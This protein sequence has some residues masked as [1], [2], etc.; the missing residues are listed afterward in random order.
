MECLTRRERDPVTPWIGGKVR[1]THVL[2]EG[3]MGVVWAGRHDAIAMD[4]A[5]KLASRQVASEVAGS[6]LRREARVAARHSHPAL[7]RVFDFGRTESGEFYLVMERLHGGTLADLLEREGPL[8]PK[9]A[10]RVLLPIA[11]ALETLH[12]GG[13]VHRD[14]KPGN[15][16]LA[17]DDSNR[18]QPKLLD[19]GISQ[20]DDPDHELGPP[21]VDRG[22]VGTPGFLAPEQALRERTDGRADIWGLCVTLFVAIAGKSLFA[23]DGL[24]PIIATRQEGHAVDTAAAFPSLPRKLARIMNKGLAPL[25][26]NRWPTMASLRRVLADWLEAQGVTTDVAGVALS[27]YVTMPRVS[28]QPDTP[29]PSQGDATRRSTNPDVESAVEPPGNPRRRGW[30]DL[31]AGVLAYAGIAVRATAAVL[32]GARAAQPSLRASR[33]LA[34]GYAVGGEHGQ[35]HW[36]RVVGNVERGEEIVSV[37]T[38]HGL[39]VANLATWS[40]LAADAKTIRSFVP[41]ITAGPRRLRVELGGIRLVFEEGAE[42]AYVAAIARAMR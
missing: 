19:F 6:R 10:V 35:D 38:R 8:A 12:K 33:L 20:I 39:S 36:K 23:G 17:R 14:I 21:L 28:S 29:L 34:G 25:A 18:L 30:R 1:L 27:E 5:V 7:V 15:I 16:A 22:P 42:P 40:R 37:A 24:A 31:S 41:T 2:A 9:L 32:R 26:A 13:I 11:A 3:G 4:V